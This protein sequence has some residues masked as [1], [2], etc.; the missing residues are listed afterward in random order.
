MLCLIS[1]SG[2]VRYYK[3]QDIRSRLAGSV[4][5]MDRIMG[6][7]GADLQGKKI[8]CVNSGALCG[9]LIGRMKRSLQEIR[10]HRDNLVRIQ[11]DFDRLAGGKKRIRS[12]HPQWEPLQQ[13]KAR[14]ERLQAQAAA[15]GKKYQQQ[16]NTLAKRL[17][18][19]QRKVSP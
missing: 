4:Q 17:Q 3:V 19:D 9:D 2:C 10:G 16:T 6:K 12:D 18:M 1:V 11:G 13:L 7:I 14:E 8:R 15:A 5:E